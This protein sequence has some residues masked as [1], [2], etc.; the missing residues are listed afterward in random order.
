MCVGGRVSAKKCVL[1]KG[2]GPGKLWDVFQVVFRS[3]GV[4][5]MK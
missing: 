5:D 3:A 1:F 2:Q 4:W